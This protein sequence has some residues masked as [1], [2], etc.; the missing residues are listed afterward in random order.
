MKPSSRTE[1]KFLIDIDDIIKTKENWDISEVEKHLEEINVKIILKY[2]TKNGFH[3][4]VEPFN[5]NEWNSEFGEIKK[6]GLLLL[7]F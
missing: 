3:I 4:I 6:D 1:T 5:P 7:S 2:P